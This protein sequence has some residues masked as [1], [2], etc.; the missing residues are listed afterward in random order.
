MTVRQWDR[1]VFIYLPGARAVVRAPVSL[2]NIG[3]KKKFFQKSYEKRLT[4]IPQC[5]I[6]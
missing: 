2:R 4:N 1:T 3:N 5:A 6:I